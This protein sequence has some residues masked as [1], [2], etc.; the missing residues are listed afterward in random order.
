M[1]DVTVELVLKLLPCIIALHRQLVRLYAEPLG[2]VALGHRA[3]VPAL[4]QLEAH[5]GKVTVSNGRDGPGLVCIAR[6]GSVSAEREQA[7]LNESSPTRLEREE[8]V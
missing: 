3:H 1:L 2:H 8:A 6:R 7:P 4:Q 5:L